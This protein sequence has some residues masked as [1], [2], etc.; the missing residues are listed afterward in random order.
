[1]VMAE[2]IEMERRALYNAL[3]INWLADPSLEVE[4]WQVENYREMSLPLLFSRLRQHG[5]NLDKDSFIRIS[6]NFDAPEEMH[7]HLVEEEGLSAV[8]EDQIYL[9]LFELWR[10]LQKDKPCLSVFCDE[11][12]H[13]IYLYDQGHLYSIEN[14]Q[15]II[16]NLQVILEENSDEGVDAEEVFRLINQNCAND[17]EAFLF[18]F[19]VEQIEGNNFSYA[20]D[21]IE[22]F[23]DYVGD[24]KWFKLLNARILSH[25]DS[26]S[27][28]VA[29]QNT[30][31]IAMDSNDLE[32]N[33]EVLAELAHESER[34]IFV[35]LVN[36]SLP[37]LKTEED[38]QDL[39]TITA[40][41]FNLLDQ[42][43]LYQLMQ[44]LLKKRSNISLSRPFH[45]KDVDLQA[46][47]KSF[48]K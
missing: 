28:K 31:D 9:L 3:R 41:Y 46:Y 33:L 23:Y 20:Q 39:I 14:I 47:L 8:E 37:L 36:K 30:V 25:T 7:E 40:D 38:F 22:S 21:L 43:D 16:A 35:D 10:R 34:D 5:L 26:E 32:Y 11:L 48:Q 1:V 45:N 12:D 18:D 44:N 15:D 13:Q 4:P 2:E 6:E 42:D 29:V 27:A 19:I 17:I 24:K